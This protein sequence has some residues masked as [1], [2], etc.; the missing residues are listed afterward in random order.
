V[1]IFSF[2]SSVRNIL[3]LRKIS[4]KSLKSIETNKLAEVK[5]SIYALRAKK[6]NEMKK[7]KHKIQWANFGLLDLTHRIIRS[8]RGKKKK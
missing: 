7:A 6:I 2:F 3:G 1:K 5:K 8:L 4:H